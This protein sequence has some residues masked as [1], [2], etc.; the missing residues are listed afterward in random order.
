MIAWQRAFKV[1]DGL[2][3]ISST[4][5][6]GNC[7]KCSSLLQWLQ[8]RAISGPRSHLGQKIFTEVVSADIKEEIC[9]LA[10]SNNILILLS[11]TLLNRCRVNKSQVWAWKKVGVVWWWI[12]LITHNA[13]QCH[14]E[15]MQTKV[16]ETMSHGPCCRSLLLDGG[17]SSFDGT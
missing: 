1:G 13:L 9:Q 11:K 14:G 15:A 8:E 6:R 17:S 7:E 4:A 12:F 16:C 3:M 5:T 2:V 10:G